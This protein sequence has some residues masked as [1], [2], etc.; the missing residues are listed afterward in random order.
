MGRKGGCNAL[1]ARITHLGN[2]HMIRQYKY[3]L[4]VS[5]C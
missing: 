4:P 3:M 1:L 5:L 2:S